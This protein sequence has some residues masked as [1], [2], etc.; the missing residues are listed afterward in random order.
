MTS[1]PHRRLAL[2]VDCDTFEGTKTGLPNLLRLLDR[3]GIRATFFFTL[4]PDRSGRAI[5]RVFTHK[6]FLRKM[7][8][9]RAVSLYGPK[10]L[11]YGTL[12]PSPMIGFRLKTEIQ[13]VAAMGHE[14]GVHG[15]DHVRWHD[16]LDQ[17]SQMEIEHQVRQAHIV[18]ENIF[19]RRARSSAAPGWHATET[20]LSIQERQGLLYASDTRGGSPF[21]PVAGNRRFNFLE[22][23]T[24]L[25]TWDESL[26]DPRFTDREAL[27]EFYAKA[28]KNTE[29]HTLHAEVEG[30]V[31]LPLFEKQLALWKS[32]GISFLTLEELAR[33][34]LSLPSM[35]PERRL[36]RITI[37]NRGGA[38]SSSL[39]QDAMAYAN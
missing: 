4:G 5:R 28:V 23:P 17:M 18:F 36:H 34:V 26:A 33:E 19:G 30:T 38:V 35:V 7:L 11:L 37:P 27:L 22:I 3:N 6:G 39:V 16:Q 25:P 8:R 21:F 29:V 31:Y 2:K 20:S 14:T 24:T 13:S 9:S 12:L 15:W 1:S 32:Q 10:T